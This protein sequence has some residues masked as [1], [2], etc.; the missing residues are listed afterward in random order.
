MKMMY[1]EFTDNDYHAR[2][3]GKFGP[4]LIV[5]FFKFRN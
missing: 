3:I 4:D 2:K 5:H 1:A